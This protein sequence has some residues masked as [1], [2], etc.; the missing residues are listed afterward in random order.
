MFAGL[1]GA[2]ISVALK[3]V[4]GNMVSGALLLW[5]KTIKKNDVITIAKTE[6]SETGSSYAVVKK[7]TLRN[8]I[9]EDRNEVRRL[10]PNSILTNSVVENWTHGG[11]L[12]RLA[13]EVP[14]A[15]GSD[16]HLARE[17]LE[18][19][20]YEVE[21]VVKHP[22]RPVAV[23]SSFGDS[24]IAFSLRFWIQNAHEGIRPVLSAV[25]W[26]AWERLK[27]EGIQIPF[28]QR[29]VH[30]FMGEGHEVAALP[31]EVAKARQE[32]DQSGET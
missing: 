14:V 28:P 7:M 15:Y 24:G 31:F 21:K 4:I 19:V 16:L 26:H 11:N 5:D 22:N 32:K 8:T 23:I 27:Q 30:L 10:I 6:G 1:L 13:V 12:V 20:C 18:S 17:I 2:G 3:D 29:D 25:R 9:V